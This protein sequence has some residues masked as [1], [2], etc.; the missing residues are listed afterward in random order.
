MSNPKKTPAKRI[1][2]L[3]LKMVREKPSILYPQRKISSPRE[4]AELFRQFIGDSDREVFCI[5]TLDTKNQ[6]TALHEV[7]RGT[8]NASLVHPRETF[9]LAIMA[10]AASIIACHNHPSGLPDPSREDVELTER[11]RD[12]GSLM[13]IELL[14]HLV[15]GE[16]RFASMKERG[17][18]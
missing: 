6:P 18:M 12:A 5:M 3:S 16:N 9:K 7:S 11:I 14:D 15:L 8:L 2:C 17:L 13:G 4:A 1:Q 10:N